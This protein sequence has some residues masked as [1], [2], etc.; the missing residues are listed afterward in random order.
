M[1]V[2]RSPVNVIEGVAALP[3]AAPTV[4]F[5]P[6]IALLTLPVSPV[7]TTVPVTSGS[8]IVLSDATDAGACK[9]MK[10]VPLPDASLKRT[11]CWLS[12]TSAPVMVS[13]LALTNSPVS[14]CQTLPSQIFSS[15]FVPLVSSHCSPLLLPAWPPA[16][17]LTFGAVAPTCTGP[18]FTESPLLSLKNK[19]GLTRLVFIANCPSLIAA[20]VGRLLAVDERRC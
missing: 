10:L 16:P 12:I 2:L 3:A 7:V 9:A 6:S 13:P 1:P 20:G 15:G 18:I 17:G 14:L 5:V 11:C 4:K 19:P 8:V